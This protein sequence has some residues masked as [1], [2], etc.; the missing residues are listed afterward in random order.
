MGGTRIRLL[1][2]QLSN[3]HVEMFEGLVT[4]YKKTDVDTNNVYK[5]ALV[6][7]YADARSPDPISFGFSLRQP[8]TICDIRAY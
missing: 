6:T 8:A 2:H 4:I 7:H 1:R 3:E 5:D